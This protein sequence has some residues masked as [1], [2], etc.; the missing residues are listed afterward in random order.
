MAFFNKFLA[1]IYLKRRGGRQVV[2]ALLT[3]TQSMNRDDISDDEKDEAASLLKEIIESS[4][5][6][7]PQ[8]LK[9]QA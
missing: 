6:A 4:K 5:K 3:Q 1:K 9:P 2:I 8:R 7:V